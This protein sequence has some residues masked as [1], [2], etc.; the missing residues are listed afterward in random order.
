MA[1][2]TP[3]QRLANEKWAKKNEKKLGKPKVKAKDQASK[4]PI[5]KPWVIGLLF[6]LIG[7]GVLQ[8]ISLLL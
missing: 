8:L 3:R 7:G 1:I 4:L 5:S 6:L 2:Q